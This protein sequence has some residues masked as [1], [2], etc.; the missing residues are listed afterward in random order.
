[1]QHTYLRYECADS[2]SLATSAG[3]TATPTTKTLVH[4]PSSIVLSTAGSQIV[5]FNLR[6]HE[7]CLKIAH[8]QYSHGGIGTG[9]ALNSDIVLCLALS[10]SSSPSSSSSNN[11]V[12]T[13]SILYKVASG[14]NDGAVRIFD[15]YE[16][17][18]NPKNYMK[19]Q[20]LGLAHSLLSTESSTEEFITREPLLLNGHLNSPVTCLAFDS[21]QPLQ[22]SQIQSSGRLASGS[23][24]GTIIIWDILA[25]TGLFRFLGHRG[26]ITDLGFV[27]LVPSSDQK[28]PR[29]SFEGL[30]SSSLDSLVKV[31]DLDAQCSMQTIANHGGDVSC[32]SVIYIPRHTP[33]AEIA[34]EGRWRLIS[35]CSDGKVRVWNISQSKRMQKTANG[36]GAKDTLTND[37]KISEVRA[38]VFNYLCGNSHA[39][40]CDSK[41]YYMT[42]LIKHS[43]NYY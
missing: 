19:S 42:L 5:G 17:E 22:G 7:P 28:S 20:R 18:L 8:R 2:F 25:E 38:Y 23:S 12:E 32:S 29:S 9:R 6:T 39:I 27:A 41:T 26:S 24:D 14:W 30:I 15:V 36:D 13:S 10:S 34:A 31:W 16:H 1:M 35:G 43:D 40:I 3:S 11:E 21:I 37:T 33:E 4:L